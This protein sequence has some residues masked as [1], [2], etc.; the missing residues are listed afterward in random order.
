MVEHKC[1]NICIVAPGGKNV[2]GDIAKIYGDILSQGGFNCIFID[3]KPFLKFKMFFDLIVKKSKYDCIHVHTSGYLGDIP[4]IWTYVVSKLFNKKI[5]ITWHCG[6][7]S[8]ILH[9][10]H[11][12]VNI[13]FKSANLVTVPSKYSRNIVLKYFSKFNDKLIVF[14]NLL[15]HVNFNCS[16]LKK[17]KNK[18]ITVSSINKWYIYRKGLV[19][20]VESAKYLPN[21]NFYLVGK[22]DDSISELKKKSPDNVHFTGYLSDTELVKLYCSSDVYCQLSVYESFGY[23]LAEAMLCG[24]VPVVTRNASLPEVVGDAGYYLEKS[25]PDHI[26]IKIKEASIS[27]MGDKAREQIV[28]NYSIEKMK[29]DFL[30]IIQNICFGNNTK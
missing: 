20:F 23:A 10:T 24:C 28:N 6:S 30:K 4:L 17:G 3:S 13:F 21:Y 15:D 25:T 12:I 22:Y 27:K 18:V 8:L 14:P 29:S 2:I 9:K 7:P 1:G 5:I 26:A 16:G 19:Q 11:P